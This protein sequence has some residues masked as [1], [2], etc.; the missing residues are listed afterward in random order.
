MA[1][2]FHQR[3]RQLFD[4]A[5]EL[6]EAQRRTFV[7]SA[8]AGDPELFEAVERLLSAREDAGAFRKADADPV[9]RIGRYIIRGELGRGGMGVVYDA[10]D[11]MIGRSVAVKVI[12][13]NAG[14]EPGRAEFMTGQLFREARS[15]GRLFHPNIVIIFDVGQEAGSAFIAMEKVDG[16]S[17]QQVLA[18][19]RVLNTEETLRL[20]QQTA[21]ALDYAHQ[22]GVIHRDIK[23]A[24]IVLQN[25]TIVKV[26]DFGIAKVISNQTTTMANVVMGTPGYMSPEQIEARPVDG[27]SDQFSLAVLAYELLTGGKPFEADSM[28]TLAHLIVYGQRP[29]ARAANPALPVEVDQVFQRGLARLA[30]ERFESCSALVGALESGLKQAYAPRVTEPLPA[31]PKRKEPAAP[32]SRKTLLYVAALAAVLAAGGGGLFLYKPAYFGSAPTREASAPPTLPVTRREPDSA[33]PPV[34]P[35]T[36]PVSP[37]K[38]DT[39]AQQPSA[40]KAKIKPQLPEEPEGP[41]GKQQATVQTITPSP[42]D[43]AREFYEAASA[44]RR[45]GQAEQATQLLRQAAELGEVVAMTELGEAYRDGEGV[46]EDQGQAMQWFRRAADAGSSSGMVLLGA[47]Y[48]LENVPGASDEEAARWFQKAADRENP[49]GLYDLASMYESGR[50]VTRNLATAQQLYRRAATLGNGEAQRRLT[51][52]QLHK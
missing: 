7:H 28:P 42:A 48:L 23:P 29:S 47:M 46:T 25:G 21:A 30:E 2:E 43:R 52:L 10:I 51:Q 13:L 8:C 5:I 45:D 9:D 39:R 17:L 36:P 40:A 15:A 31:L 35:V 20:L 18:S 14:S 50:G 3:M 24:N 22:N 6:P 27:R 19:G 26:A 37:A 11:P 4:Q 1:L 34:S 32:S 41:A 33:P 12:N 38:E 44:K 49:A 16:P